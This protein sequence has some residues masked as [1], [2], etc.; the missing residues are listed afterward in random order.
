MSG[1]KKGQSNTPIVSVLNMKGGVGKTTVA[2]NLFYEI[3]HEIDKPTLFLDLDAQFNLTQLL[4]TATFYD[5]VQKDGRTIFHVFQ[6]DVPASVFAVSDQYHLNL[7]PLSSYLV[8][9]PNSKIQMLPG[10]F[11]LAMLSL[12]NPR[13][14]VIPRK[15]FKAFIEEAKDVFGLIVID[16]NPSTSFLTQCA[17]E[18]SSHLLIPVRPDKFSLR[19]VEMVHQYVVSYLG[20]DWPLDKKILVNEAAA[21]DR[22]EPALV[23]LRS[24]KYGINVL[25]N[26]LKFSKILRA[27]TDYTGFATKKGGP[28]SGN[29]GRHIKT[30]ATEYSGLLG[31]K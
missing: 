30:I 29:L 12:R 11:K 19:G 23:E 17:L 26:E 14:L 20:P 31:L 1:S 25:S 15:R 10:D 22:D 9:F 4:L 27:K 5:K 3:S 28:W 16:C 24:S 6:H 18:V 7:R 8:S 2:A 13:D 21:E